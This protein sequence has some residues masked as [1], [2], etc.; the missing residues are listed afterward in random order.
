ML[1]ETGS[2]AFSAPIG[3][4]VGGWRNKYSRV[5]KPQGLFE[6]LVVNNRFTAFLNVFVALRIY[7]TMPV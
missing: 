5:A 4:L 6:Y 3:W 2:P 1:S 7:L